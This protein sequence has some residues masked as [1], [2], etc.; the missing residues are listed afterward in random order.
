[1]L[2]NMH[3]TIVNEPTWALFKDWY[4]AG[5]EIA[6]NVIATGRA[7][8]L[9]VEVYPVTLQVLHRLIT[10]RD[11]ILGVLNVPLAHSWSPR[12]GL[13][14]AGRVKILHCERPLRAH[15]RLHFFSCWIVSL[16]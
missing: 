6:R 15:C 1:M 5:P 8:T 10:T 9:V 2:E 4:S 7:Q 12:E 11:F 14:A 3:Y 13:L 16:F